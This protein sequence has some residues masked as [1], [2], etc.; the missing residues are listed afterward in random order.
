MKA[1]TKN[2]QSQCWRIAWRIVA[3]SVIASVI[4]GLLLP[5]GSALQSAWGKLAMGPIIPGIALMFKLGA[6]IDCGY[7]ARFLLACS[8]GIGFDLICLYWVVR[9]VRGL[10]HAGSNLSRRAER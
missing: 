3:A 5:A 1:P 6:L 9:G 4:V 2:E 7:V 8:V 10:V